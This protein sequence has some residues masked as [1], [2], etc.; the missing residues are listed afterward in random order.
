MINYSWKENEWER[1][2]GGWR[3]CEERWRIKRKEIGG[4]CGYGDLLGSARPPTSVK[5]KTFSRNIL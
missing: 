2:K 3:K 4:K 5:T 1:L